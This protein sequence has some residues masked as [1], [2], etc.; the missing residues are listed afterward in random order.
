MQPDPSLKATAANSFAVTI[1]IRASPAQVFW[2]LADP[3]TAPIIDPAVISYAPDGGTMG[4]GVRNHMKLRL[5][6]V[7][8]NITSETTDWEP[9]SRMAF[10]S[11]TPGRPVIVT[12]THLFEPCTAGT[13]Y[14]WSMGFTPKGIGGR[15]AARC[16][17]ALLR[18]NAV[19]Q[20]ERVRTVIEAVND[21]RRT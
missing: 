12:A 2:F 17:A 9:G 21:A 15:L 16:V 10:R 7:T 6:G 5:L 1:E 3:S 13:C 19:A 4:L 14:T 18:R 8:R 20:Q 11:L